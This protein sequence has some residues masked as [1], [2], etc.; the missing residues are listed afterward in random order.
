[1]LPIGLDG[2]RCKPTSRKVGNLVHNPLML[3][4]KRRA[5][6][7]VYLLIPGDAVS[8]HRPLSCRFYLRTRQW[9]VRADGDSAIDAVTIA[10]R[11][12]I[13]FVRSTASSMGGQRTQEIGSARNV[14]ILSDGSNK[15]K[16]I[17]DRGLIHVSG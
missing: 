6:V 14:A 3:C 9:L 11:D 5:I 16:R 10:T 4:T 15:S 2:A 1:M 7:V 13:G 12:G 8:L 17:S